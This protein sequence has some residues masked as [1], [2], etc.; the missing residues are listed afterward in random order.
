MLKV[1]RRGGFSDRQGINP[2]NANIQ[3]NDFDK[4]T[5]IQLFNLVSNS[6]KEIYGNDYWGNTT[7]KEF[8]CYVYQEIFCETVNPGS[9]ISDDMFFKDM[10]DVFLN[11]SY[12]DILTFIEALSDYWKNENVHLES[13]E[14]Y[15]DVRHAYNIPEVF[16]NL[17]KKEYIGYRFIGGKISPISDEMEVDTITETLN[18]TY[19]QV[20]MH[21]SK[22]HALL[23]DR[24]RPDYENSIKESI[25]AVEAMCEIITGIKGKEA[26][27]GTML[28]KLES[29]GV[30]IHSALKSAFNTLYGYTSDANGIRHAGDIGGEAS[31]FE[32][33]K[34]MLISCCAFINYLKGVSAD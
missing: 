6:Y 7:I 14:N 5:R 30:V 28:K 19:A 26:T 1:N 34:F 18:D 33:A 17:F 32:E 27:L 16:N 23:A 11:A 10:K 2:I 25:S 3:V 24:E 15:Y 9:Y 12:D 22:A 8:L 20:S 4:R 29:N 13:D 21:I 31:T